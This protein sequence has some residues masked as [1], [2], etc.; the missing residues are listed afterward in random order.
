MNPLHL[1]RDLL[2]LV[3]IAMIYMM[4]SAQLVRVE[5]NCYTPCFIV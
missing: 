2:L 3:E 4:D 1:R 5:S